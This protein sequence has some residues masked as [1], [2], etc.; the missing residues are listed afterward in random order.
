VS[1]EMKITNEQNLRNTV[2][3]VLKQL[4]EA[5]EKKGQ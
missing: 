2:I 4:E 1:D 5:A 3:I